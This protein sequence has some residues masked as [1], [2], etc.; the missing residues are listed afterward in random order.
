MNFNNIPVEVKTNFLNLFQIIF[1][2]G[3]S[4]FLITV[5]FFLIQSQIHKD[6]SDQT[7]Y[8]NFQ[9]YGL[10][11]SIMAIIFLI[12]GYVLFVGVKF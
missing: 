4:V 11:F 8:K 3:I 1:V 9:R 7:G 10:S 5:V 2:V 6:L 12:L